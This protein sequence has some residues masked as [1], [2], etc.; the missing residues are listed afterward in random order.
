MLKVPQYVPASLHHLLNRYVRTA[1]LKNLTRA[2]KQTK[3]QKFTKKK[4]TFKVGDTYTW[5]PEDGFMG[6][7]KMGGISWLNIAKVQH[8]HLHPHHFTTT[9]TTTISL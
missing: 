5:V 7:E 9:T 2:C 6:N 3:I 8:P 4:I 1:S